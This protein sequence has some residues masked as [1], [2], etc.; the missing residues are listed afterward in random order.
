M[1]ND[2]EDYIGGLLTVGSI[3]YRDPAAA[4]IDYDQDDL[5]VDSLSHELDL[6][7]IVPAGAVAIILRCEATGSSSWSMLFTAK[8]DSGSQASFSVIGSPSAGVV[9]SVWP[10]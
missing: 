3:V 5:I 1:P 4:S 9:A 10:R 2:T 7:G 8:G 6:S